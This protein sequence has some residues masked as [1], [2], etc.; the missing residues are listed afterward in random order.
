MIEIYTDGS[1]FPNPGNGGWAYILKYED[2][3]EESSAHCSG[4][5]TNNQMELEAIFRALLELK[6]ESK[7]HKIIIY[8]DSQ[9]AINAC[10]GTWN[11]TKNVEKVKEVR[12]LIFKEGWDI[13]WKWVKGHDGN[14]YNEKCDKLAFA[15]MKEEI[16]TLSR[17]N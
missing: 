16:G 8:S 7:N 15:A 17:Y 9:W 3:I 5:V 11:I 13:T 1:T 2:F 4:L 14:E 10:K 12:S 6:P